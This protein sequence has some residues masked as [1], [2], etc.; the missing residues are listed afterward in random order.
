[1]FWPLCVSFHKR[2]K[3]TES[4]SVVNGTQIHAICMPFM[5]FAPTSAIM[6]KNAFTSDPQVSFFY[7]PLKLG[8]LNVQRSIAA[9]GSTLISRSALMLRVTAAVAICESISVK[10]LERKGMEEMQRVRE[11]KD[12]GT[13]CT[14]GGKDREGERRREGETSACLMVI[15]DITYTNNEAE[16]DNIFCMT[17][18]F[19]KAVLTQRNGTLNHPRGPDV[20]TQWRTDTSKHTCTHE[21]FHFTF[22]SSMSNKLRDYKGRGGDTGSLCVMGICLVYQSIDS[23]S[24]DGRKCRC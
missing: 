14:I 3:N 24:K 5:V 1:M 4:Y 20:Y 7:R 2:K 17:S 8:I 21:R 12:D 18:V 23:H 15:G 11:Q 6:A 22:S 19:V 10:P 9:L 13:I 16:D